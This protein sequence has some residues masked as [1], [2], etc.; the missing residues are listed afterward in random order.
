ME[1]SARSADE[2]I[3]N[4]LEYVL[5]YFNEK[6]LRLNLFVC[7]IQKKIFNYLLFLFNFATQVY[8]CI[9]TPLYI[10]QESR[11]VFRSYLTVIN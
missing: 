11:H 7:L 8:M 4:N 6:G 2:V 3:Q 9:G 10:R 5:H 1:R